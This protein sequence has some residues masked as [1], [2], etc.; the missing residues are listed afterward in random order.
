MKPSEWIKEKVDSESGV[1]SYSDLEYLQA[2]LGAVMAY[3]DIE[4]QKRSIPFLDEPLDPKDM[5]KALEAFENLSNRDVDPVGT[6]HARN[7]KFL[8]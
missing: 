2:L 5:E 4:W 3:M 7:P 1:G 8:D 6:S